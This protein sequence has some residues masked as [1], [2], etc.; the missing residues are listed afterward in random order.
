MVT[1]TASARGGALVLVSGGGSQ[2]DGTRLNATLRW[3]HMS[4][5]TNLV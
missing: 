5:M 2:E 3:H 1:V 4:D